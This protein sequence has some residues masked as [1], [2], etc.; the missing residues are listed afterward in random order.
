MST[1]AVSGELSWY[2]VRCVFEI[3]K[4]LYEERITMWSC[5]SFE[6]AIELAEVEAQEYVA[7]AGIDGYVGLAQAFL[8]GRDQPT[9][10]SEIFSLLRESPLSPQEYV[11]KYFDTGGERH[12]GADTNAE[13]TE[14]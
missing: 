4:G 3:D 10:G 12:G 13:S 14:P 2:A 9:S 8:I 1:D 11:S 6:R 5:N 7:S